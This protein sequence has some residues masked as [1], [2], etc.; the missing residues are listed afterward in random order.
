MR[1]SQAGFTPPAEEEEAP[2]TGKGDP[3]SALK[4]AEAAL[5]Q[6]SPLTVRCTQWASCCRSAVR[7]NQLLGHVA[8]P[9]LHLRRCRLAAMS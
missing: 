9:H 4:R 5:R 7:R 6:C 2:A 3:S 1:D 8:C